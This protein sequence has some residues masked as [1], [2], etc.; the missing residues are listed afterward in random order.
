MNRSKQPFVFPMFFFGMLC[1]AIS[2]SPANAKTQP[3]I[4]IILA[5]D[6]GYGDMGCMGSHFLVTPHLDALAESGVLC[7][8]GYVASSVCSPSRAGLLTGRD[9]RRFGYEEN[10]NQGAA[11]Y[12][13]RPDLLGLPPGEFTLGDHLRAAGYATALIGKWHQ[14]MSEEF[15]PNSRGFDH[16]C[17][18]LGG[19]HDYFP[20]PGKHHLQRNGEPLTEF[21]NDYLTDFFTDEGL[22]FI[23][24]QKSQES[25]KP[26]FIFFSYNAPHGPLQAT[27]ADLAMFEH[28]PNQKRR[29]YAAMMFALDRGVGRIREHLRENGQ[30]ENTLIVF[31]SD[32]GGATGNASWNGPLSGVKGT[33]LEG[34][35]RVPTIYSW[36][37]V[38]PAGARHD[39][40]VSSLDLLPTFMAAADAEPLPLA[41]VRPHEDA[42]NRKRIVA[43]YGEYDGINLLPQLLR[44]AEPKR[45]TLFWRLQGQA[46]VLDGDEK[47]IRLSHRP[48]QVFRPSIDVGERED[49][50]NQNSTRTS[51]LFQQLGEWESLLP[52]GPLWA[53]SPYW[54]GESSTLYDSYDVRDEPHE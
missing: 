14:G 16:F 53:S 35:V 11:S 25:T 41:T 20:K 49:L 48:A 5:D 28:I 44:Q 17:G 29:T 12:A 39:S 22:R 36:P 50:I 13:T 7:T 47:L 31:F 23:E 1:I 27:E 37:S 38:L 4:M 33:L 45:R 30:L 32:N 34:G 26:W 10:L 24:N 2:T 54:T 8:Q 21:S 52:T 51:E 43:K 19:S 15:H 6:M 18:M 40:P 42:K 46:S 3:N 9:P